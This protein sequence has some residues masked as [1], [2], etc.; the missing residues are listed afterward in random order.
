LV[1]ACSPAPRG[2]PL[3]AEERALE[4]RSFDQIWTTVRERHWD[5][6]VYGPSWE[7]I[8]D[9]LRPRIEQA[10]TRAESRAVMQALLD[11]LGQ[12]HFGIIPA[13]VYG[14][15]TVDHSDRTPEGAESADGEGASDALDGGKDSSDILT[16]G[17][18]VTGLDLRILDG[19]AVVTRV[20]SGSPAESVGVRPGWIL[21]QARNHKPEV[22]LP[23]LWEEFEESTARELLAT[24]AVISWLRGPIGG[25]V[26]AT[27][28]DERDRQVELRLP[29]IEPPGKKTQFGNLPP[30]YAEIEARRLPGEIGY[31][32]VSMF[33]D[34]A[35]VMSA[36]NEAMS[37]YL[38]APGVILDLRGNPGGLGAMAMGMAG[39]FVEGEGRRLGVMKTRETEFKFTINPRARTYTAP[40]AVLIDGLSASTSEILAGGLQGLGRARLFG[41]ATAG[42]AL[43]SAIVKLPNGDGFQYAFANYTAEGGAVLEGSGVVP[44]VLAPPT[45]EALLRGED[46][47]LA[48]AVQWIHSSH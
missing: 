26:A 9:T 44:D 45:R 28:L 15:M 29:L 24:S 38:D 10:R 6:E 22:V 27:F 33:F 32:R 3:S 42:A 14:E 30:M 5:P 40:L 21:L 16:S 25:E 41:T 34:P 37:S 1:V 11:T 2:R 20:A 8:R 35:G 31:I 23:K 36:F 19:R 4:V 48:A 39:W 13:D 47:A 43:P 46:P 18:G 17:A 7:A 12:S